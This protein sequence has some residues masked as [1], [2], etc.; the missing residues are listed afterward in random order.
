MAV[1]STR[2]QNWLNGIGHRLGYVMNDMAG[3]TLAV[4]PTSGTP[5]TNL[6][7]AHGL[8]DQITGAALAPTY[9][10]VVTG[11]L[12]VVS[13]DATNVVVASTAATQSGTLRLIAFAS[14]GY[15]GS[16]VY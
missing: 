11:N 12:Y 14:D 16:R 2:F 7:V 9:V 4:G 3:T 15:T 10:H 13:F 6:T 1:F 5:N 8:T